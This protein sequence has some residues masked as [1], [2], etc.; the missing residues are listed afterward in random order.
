M[1]G[2]L[3]DLTSGAHYRENRRIVQPPRR[4]PGNAWDG[5]AAVAGC[6][7]GV[8]AAGPGLCLLC[9]I[10][11]PRAQT[12]RRGPRALAVRPGTTVAV[13]PVIMAVTTVTTQ[14]TAIAPEHDLLAQMA[15][16]RPTLVRHAFLLT[17]NKAD[18]EDLAQTAFER[19]LRHRRALE[20]NTHVA[21]L[22]TRI[23]RNLAI[24]Q[25]RHAW[26]VRASSDGLTEIPG[27]EPEAQPWWADIDSDEV[28]HALVDCPPR[29]R[30]TFE[31][32]HYGHLSLRQISQRTGA[33]VKT[34]ATRIFRARKHL[35]C[36]LASKHSAR[37]QAIAAELGSRRP[38]PS[39]STAR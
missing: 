21:A 35:R 34:V 29:L 1:R 38:M 13:S 23:T 22:L 20:P 36:A 24:D 15:S 7:P 16:L 18:A 2:D 32:R 11:Y 39:Q 30:E 27:H 28:S 31:L 8:A 17:R 25:L 9:A 5:R 37:A 33:P 26:R 4:R 14:T 19:A 3:T 12:A 10:W 6:A